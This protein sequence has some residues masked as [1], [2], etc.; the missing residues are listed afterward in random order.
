M[1]AWAGMVP[2]GGMLVLGGMAWPPALRG[3]LLLALLVLVVRWPSGAG[4]AWLPVPA[5]ADSGGGMCPGIML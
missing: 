3:P 5:M 2:G 1:R 4:P